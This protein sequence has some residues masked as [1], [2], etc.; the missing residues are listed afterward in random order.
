[1]KVI[2]TLIFVFAVIIAL[3]GFSQDLIYKING[4]VVECEIA[5]IDGQFVNYTKN[6]YSGSKMFSLPKSQ[7]KKI[8]YESSQVDSVLV[9]NPVREVNL[10]KNLQS[11][12]RNIYKMGVFSPL[13]GALSIGFERSLKP[14]RSYEAYVGFIGAGTDINE[15]AIG[16][17]GRLG[18]KLYRNPKYYQQTGDDAHLMHGFFIMPSIMVS[19]FEYDEWSYNNSSWNGDKIRTDAYS[20]AVILSMGKQWIF[21]DEFSLQINIGAGYAISSDDIFYYSHIAYGND[22]PLALSCGVSFGFLN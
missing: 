2:K 14:T 5:S 11:Q 13:T 7:V 1:M 16:A 15:N 19:Y 20:V 4:E 3:T 17:Y 6:R 9:Y 10:E 18:Y 21:D 12:N 8:V 22:F